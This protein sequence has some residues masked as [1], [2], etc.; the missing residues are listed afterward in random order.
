MDY[1]Q[2]F[3]IDLR[4]LYGQKLDKLAAN[5]DKKFAQINKGIGTVSG[6]G[7]KAAK[8]IDEIGKR[9]DH[10]KDRINLSVDTSSIKAANREMQ[11][12]QKERDKLENLGGKRGG[13]LGSAIGG[14]G[15]GFLV[16]TLATIGIG[17]IGNIVDKAVESTSKYEKFEAVL[18][19]TLGSRGI[20]KNVMDSITDFATK[21][22]FQVD[23]LTSGFVKLANQGFTPT[24]KQM[25]S[26][27][28]LASSTGKSY[29]QL[30]E[31]LLDA[32]T[33]EF[34]R[35]K[36]FGIRA[37][38]HNEK[39]T[40]TFKGVS[41]TV[42]KTAEAMRNYILT[43]GDAKGVT[44][45]M[46][47]ISAT[48]GGAISNLSDNVDLLWKDLG[49][50][51]NPEIKSGTNL[52]SKFVGTIRS[53][54]AIPTE[55]KITDEIIKIRE[56]QVELTSTNTSEERRKEILNELHE[57]NPKITEGISDQSIEYGKLATNIERV[58]S[59]LRD[60]VAAE[61][62]NKEFSSKL[63]NYYDLQKRKEETTQRLRSQA[64]EL[65]P[66]IAKSS[67]LTDEQKFS[68]VAQ[69]QDS[70]LNNYY[71][72]NPDKVGLS[73]PQ[74][75]YKAQYFNADVAQLAQINKELKAIEPEYQKFQDK[76]NFLMGEAD[77]K[78]GTN[79][80][81]TTPPASNPKSLDTAGINNVSSG[82]QTK[83]INITINQ[84]LGSYTVQ[85]QT[86][87]EG[88]AKSKDTVIEGLLTAV[89]DANL[90]GGNQ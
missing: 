40:F 22:P 88:V 43:L 68:L 7:N 19:N 76:K 69:R 83:N 20:A 35:L 49:E 11:A 52:I 55:K 1:R 47:K 67:L 18:S 48:T 25:T 31:A 29:D 34:E 28:D 75:G 81:I 66:I 53:W 59:G 26:L 6:T 50:R 54:I 58:V 57:L 27:G 2:T 72:D 73:M 63:S 64:Y 80:N 8:S 74:S 13:G 65:D 32:Q 38:V 77:W 37:A 90:A 5:S 46:E 15:K 85:T 16:G 14:L 79:S 82:S 84:L 10:L 3:T 24:L 39:I 89:N 56:L 30:A 44:G 41:T 33:G 87:K 51:F 61:L 70:K 21:T 45:A 71:A 23:E 4:D 36:E 42:A 17:G 86:L 62:L 9:I 60:K 78:T 12:L